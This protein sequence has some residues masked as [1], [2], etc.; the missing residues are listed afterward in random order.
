MH[1]NTL[2]NRAS[3]LEVDGPITD[4]TTDMERCRTDYGVLRSQL[5][6]M[7]FQEEPRGTTRASNTLEP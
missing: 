4:T 2:S 5:R 3:F 1:R 6:D 7:G